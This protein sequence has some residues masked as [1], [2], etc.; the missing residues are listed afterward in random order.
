MIGWTAAAPPIMEND[1]SRIFEPANWGGWALFLLMFVWQIP[2]F[3]AI[4]WRYREDYAAGGYRMLPS[5]DPAGSMTAATM[6]MWAL[7]L[8]PASLSPV[9][10]MPDRL[11][12]VYPTFAVVSGLIYAGLAARLVLRR[13][14]RAA[15]VVFFA[16]IIHLPLLLLV[17]VGDAVVNLV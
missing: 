7:A 4:A 8:I 17:M 3:L 5:E 10:F 11:A 16:S 14:D 13:S 12:V 9:L 15:R 1:L 6:F 2:H